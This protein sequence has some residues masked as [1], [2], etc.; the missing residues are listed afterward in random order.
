MI[1]PIALTRIAY[2]RSPHCEARARART[3]FIEIHCTD[4]HEGIADAEVCA[5]MFHDPKLAPK[6]SAHFVVDADSIIQCVPV[7]MIAWH[8]GHTSNHAGVGVE[9]CGLVKQTEADWRDAAS[10]ATLGR[11]ASLFRILCDLYRLPILFRDAPNLVLGR[12]GVTTHA[13]VSKAW[14]E[15]NH[16]DPGPHFPL[17]EFINA[18]RLAGSGLGRSVLV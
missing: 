16:T 6:R 5:S 2:L 11:A 8:S 10:L 1:E 17:V 9:I 12:D 15:T 13:E 3:Q 7:D 4:G 14:H 18:I